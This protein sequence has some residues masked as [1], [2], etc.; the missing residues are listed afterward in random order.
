MSLSEPLTADD[1]DRA[2]A[3]LPRVQ[4]A[5]EQEYK[6]SVDPL[7]FLGTPDVTPQA[8][9]RVLPL[10]EGATVVTRFRHIQSSIYFDDNWRLADNRLALKALVNPG[11]F[12]NLSWLFAKQ[13]IS[14]VDGCRDSLEVSARVAPQEIH[15]VVRE[16]RTLPLEYLE[17]LCGR[18]LHLDAYATTTQERNKVHLRLPDGVLFQA[19]FDVTR[20]RVLPDG[21]PVDQTWLEIESTSSD[22]RPRGALDAWASTLTDRI[23]VEPDEVSKPESA[24]RLAGW[25][26]DG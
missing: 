4:I 2:M 22:L 14:W 16:R 7:A 17:R 6:W 10:P 18:E 20:T 25:G 9:E 26:S 15:Q 19:T 3:H 1:I 8:L 24:A 21:E 11:P 12:R 5:V 23:G 13:T